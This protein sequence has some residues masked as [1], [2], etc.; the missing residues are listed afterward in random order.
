MKQSIWVRVQKSKKKPVHLR[1]CRC[2]GW[3]CLELVVSP[4]WCSEVGAG[5]CSGKGWLR[6]RWRCVG[7]RWGSLGWWRRG[8]AGPRPA[9]SRSPSE[10]DRRRWCCLHKITD[11]VFVEIDK[12]DYIEAFFWRFS[13]TIFNF[14]LA[15][16]CGLYC[17]T[18]RVFPEFL[19]LNL[20]FLY[21][22][23]FS[24]FMLNWVE[25]LHVM[26]KKS[27]GYCRKVIFL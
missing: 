13:A 4:G 1:W 12:S 9:W 20:I 14:E 19:V 11:S 21:F 7:K 17:E 6:P 2:G 5:P 8:G 16:P 23:K 22:S 18:P 24:K 25:K 3:A 15:R 27:L 10:S 26:S